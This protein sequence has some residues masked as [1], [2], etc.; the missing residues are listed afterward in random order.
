MGNLL[1][2]ITIVDDV[3][4]GKPTIRGMRITAQTVLEFIL[5]GDTDEDILES[6]PF[7]ESEDIQAVKEFALHLLANCSSMSEI[8]IVA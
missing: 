5:A 2:R 3:C 4:N 7:L 8:E 6:Y 1:N